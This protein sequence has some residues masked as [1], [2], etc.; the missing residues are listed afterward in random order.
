MQIKERENQEIR[1]RGVRN[2]LGQN[3]QQDLWS[4]YMFSNRNNNSEY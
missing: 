4:L 2:R 3:L 1:K